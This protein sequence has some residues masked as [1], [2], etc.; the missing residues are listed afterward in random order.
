IS[1]SPGELQPVFQA[2][3]ENA[4]RICGAKF[5]NLFL[6]ERA[7]FRTVATHGA[8]TAFV[9][10][11]R[12]EPLVLADSSIPP[13]RGAQTKEVVHIR[14]VRAEQAY[15]DR[16]PRMLVIESSGARTLLGV[17][18]L[19]EGN[20]IGAIAIY[21]HE[22]RPFTNKQIELVQSFANQAVIAIENA[23]L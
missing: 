2:M 23:R 4:T 22:V 14:D 1:S 8:P 5:G 3:L 16:H 18:M 12:R 21:R 10:L 13:R 9:E 19:Q 17:P 15:L 11:L 7:A 6:R 20:L